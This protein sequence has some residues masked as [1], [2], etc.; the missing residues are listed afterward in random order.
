MIFPGDAGDGEAMQIM[1][2][3][4]LLLNQ[5]KSPRTMGVMNRSKELMILQTAA[6]VGLG[7]LLAPATGDEVPLVS[8]AKRAQVIRAIKACLQGVLWDT[9]YTYVNNETGQFAPS[10]WTA[11]AALQALSRLAAA[12][13][14]HSEAVRDAAVRDAKEA[15][16]AQLRH[17]D[18]GVVFVAIQAMVTLAENG[19]AEPHWVRMRIGCS[20]GVR[21]SWKKSADEREVLVNR[22]AADAQER[23]SAAP[24]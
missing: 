6:I 4:D 12:M 11:A 2:V 22:A 7:T 18:A 21:L 17:S 5:L 1:T 24:P 9:G 23:L 8:I 14:P 15:V 13:P 3:V 10:P 20:S 19:C 16:N